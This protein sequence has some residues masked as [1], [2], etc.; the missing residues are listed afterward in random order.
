MFTFGYSSHALHNLCM[1]LVKEF[2]VVKLIVKQIIFLVKSVRKTH[3]P[4]AIRQNL[5][6]EVWNHVRAHP[7][8]ENTLGNGPR[9]RQALGSGADGDVPAADRNHVERPRR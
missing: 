4:A 5:Q 6:G 2:P 9:R 8:H 3:Y 1:D 7:V